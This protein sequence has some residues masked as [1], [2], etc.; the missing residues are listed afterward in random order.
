MTPGDTS[1]IF[2]LLLV[3]T[4]AGDELELSDQV[5]KRRIEEAGINVRAVHSSDATV[6]D[7]ANSDAVLITT[8]PHHSTVTDRFRD[9]SLPVML[10]QVDVQHYLGMTGATLDVDY[11]MGPRI[12]DIVIEDSSHPATNSFVEGELAIV[13]TVIKNM[14]Y[15]VPSNNAHVLAT[16]PGYPH[17]AVLYYYP[18]GEE[19]VG[20]TAP[21]VRFAFILMIAQV[22]HLNEDGWQIFINSLEW[23]LREG[24]GGD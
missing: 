19:M 4:V 7:T 17:Q 9:V 11:G 14:R 2:N 8:S 12:P 22:I 16:A 10:L 18:K 1:E 23:L 24:N 3:G 15:G 6:A 21:G 20:M 13:D 5:L